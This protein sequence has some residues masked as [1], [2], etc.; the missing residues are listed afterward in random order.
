MNYF[1]VPL[2]SLKNGGSSIR[3]SHDWIVNVI[4][5]VTGVP[6]DGVKIT[7]A[8]KVTAVILATFTLKVIGVTCPATSLPFVG[9]TTNQECEGV[10]TD[11]VKVFPPE[12]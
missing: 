5:T 12:F 11:H 8:E 7:I 3:F 2:D 4:F 6:T 1:Q 10:P 9:E